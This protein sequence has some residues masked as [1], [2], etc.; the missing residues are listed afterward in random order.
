MLEGSFSLTDHNGHAVTE[1]SYRGSFMLIY[2]GFT[3]CRK[4]CP[5]SLAC[6]SAALDTLGETRHM[7]VPLYITVDPER[8]TPERMKAFVEAN[9]P[10][11]TGLTGSR[12]A[13]DSAK[14]SFRV[15]SR[16]GLDPEDAEGYAMPH[17][18]FA[19]LLGPDGKYLTHFMDTV[20]DLQ[21]A[22]RLRILLAETERVT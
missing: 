7:V 22:N 10:R 16:K 6:M 1:A 2:F 4:V 13:I 3:H 18:A 19:Y 20:D 15:F 11:F 9:F 5:R 17:T 21:M 12:E 8:D 14:A